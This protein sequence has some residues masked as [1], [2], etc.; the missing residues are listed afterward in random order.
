MECCS[1]FCIDENVTQMLSCVCV[2]LHAD[3]NLQEMND[4]PISQLQS[5]A[6]INSNGTDY[7]DPTD[8][9]VLDACE[10]KY[11]YVYT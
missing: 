5:D 8:D 1:H 3:Q 6:H 4:G 9:T 7:M 10:F 2:C 11:T